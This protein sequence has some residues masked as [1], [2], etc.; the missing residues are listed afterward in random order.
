MVTDDTD[1]D[2][3]DADDGAMLEIVEAFRNAATD[4]FTSLSRAATSYEHEILNTH[5]QHY[6]LFIIYN[7]HLNKC[8][9]C[10]T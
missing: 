5:S 1:A 10:L 3:D 7:V 8:V 9:S 6:G 2:D 4:A